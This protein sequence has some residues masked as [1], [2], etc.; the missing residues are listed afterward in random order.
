[1]SYDRT[2]LKI[3]ITEEPDGVCL[4]NLNT[5][6]SLSISTIDSLSEIYKWFIA[7]KDKN[8]PGLM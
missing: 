7:E 4:K 8:T 1:M 2:K 3:E 6:E 5:N